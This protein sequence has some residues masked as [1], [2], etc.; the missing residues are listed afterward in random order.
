VPVVVLG[1]LLAWWF[2]I[3]IGTGQGTPHEFAYPYL[4]GAALLACLV[5]IVATIVA[6]VG[7]RPTTM[8]RVAAAGFGGA[9]VLNVL[10][11]AS[12]FVGVPWDQLDEVPWWGLL[13]VP[14]TFA[15]LLSLA[16]A[17]VCARL[18]RTTRWRRPW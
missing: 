17:A 12:W 15:A 8:L 13:V 7:L 2:L 11:E 10:A 4:V 5:A 6:M 9:A 16:L 14:T 3:D 1:L 18:A